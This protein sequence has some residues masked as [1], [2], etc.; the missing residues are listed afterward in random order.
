MFDPTQP[1]NNSALSSAVMRSQLTSLKALIDAI[2]SIIAAQVD[3]VVTLN[4][5]DPAF[6]TLTV[7]GSLLRFTFGIPKGNDGQTGQTGDTGQ[8]G[9]Q[10]P[11]FAQAIVDAVNTLL[12]GENAW[13]TVTFDGTHVHLTF[14]IPRGDTGAQGP[15][16]E[17]TSAQLTTAIATT[18]QNPA[19]VSPL[20]QTA[21]GTY[22]PTQMQQVMDKLDELLTATQRP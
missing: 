14:G 1:A 20:S 12:P 19:G 2:V 5:G 10:G 4:P 6:V 16:G 18:A 13:V 8:T 21:D 11:P 22:N 3:G 7:D 15:P 9:A 17:V